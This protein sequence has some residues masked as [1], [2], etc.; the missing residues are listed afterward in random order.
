M[1][2]LVLS[3]AGDATPKRIYI[4][5]A[6]ASRR[7]FT[8][9]IEAAVTAVLGA[10]GFERVYL[11]EL[12]WPAQVRLIAGA[13]S[14]AGMHGAGLTNILFADAKTL[15]E[16]HNPLEA[17]PYFAVMAREL[18]IN[19]TYIMGSLNCRTPNFDNI[20]IDLRIVEKIAKEMEAK[21]SCEPPRPSRD[22]RPP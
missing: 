20:T 4:S 10:A 13:K 12:T 16:F 2:R 11:E 17:R 6:R 15:L 8:S 21:Y 14:I 18:N 3:A 1:D 9:E 22:E 7:K 19:Y 5:R